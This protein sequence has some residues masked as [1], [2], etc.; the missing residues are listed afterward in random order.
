MNKTIGSILQLYTSLEHAVLDY[1]EQISKN[2]Q[3]RIGEVLTEQGHV[4][5][6]T[7]YKALAK[8]FNMEFLSSLDQELNVELIKEL[9]I[10]LFKNGNCLP[11]TGGGE[12]L[13]IAV[14]DP[15]DFDIIMEAS[16]ASSQSVLSVLTPPSQLKAAQSRLFEGDSFFKQSAGK[17]LREYEKKSLPR[18]DGLSVEEIRQRTESEPVVRLV[19]LIFDEAIKCRAS[20]IHIEPYEHNAQVRF[21]IDGMLKQHTEVT[22]YMY[23]P[24]TSRI[25]ILADIDIAEKRIPQDGRI[26][27]SSEEQAFDFRVSTL[28]THYGEKTVIR[29]LKHDKALLN[30]ENTGISPSQMEKINNL[31]E[32]PQGMIFVTG[33]TGS[34]KSSTLFS[35]LNR[36]RGKE[37]NITTVENPIEY[38]LEGINQVQINEKAGVTFAAALRSILRQDPDVILVGEIRD[39]ETAQIA[40]QASQTGH[41]VFSTLHTNDALSAVTRLKDLGIPGFL[42]SSSLLAILAQRLVR[43]LCPD[44]KT[45]QKMSPETKLRWRSLLGSHPLPRTF[46]AQGCERC[47]FTGFR[48]R[49]GVFELLIV[50]EEVRSMIADNISESALRKHLKGNSFVSLIEDG[51]EK[52]EQGI[53]TPEE[54]LRVVQVEDALHFQNKDE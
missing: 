25:K 30:L 23:T 53:T 6:T 32:K 15:L 47:G 19:S 22:R 44:C 5:E 8:Q 40:V 52:I 26:R 16:A 3:K 18:E 7:L 28:P 38:K 42:I 48:G 17:I 43:V 13:R 41:L 31:I 33:P 51:I 37:I 45:E 54:L 11:L 9:P 49:T 21:R 14:C 50:N 12:F 27:Y 34:G 10:E 35:C 2:G 39:S 4:D 46:A 29:I 24:L 20:D 36:I 1:A